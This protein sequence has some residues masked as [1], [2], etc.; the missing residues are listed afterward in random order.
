[1]DDRQVLRV[2]EETISIPGVEEMCVPGSVAGNSRWLPWQLVRVTIGVIVADN[3]I[4][5]T[6]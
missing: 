6:P 1:M 5:G 3:A 2:N 4:S